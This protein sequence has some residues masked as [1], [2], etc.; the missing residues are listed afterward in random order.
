MIADFC[1]DNAVPYERCGKVIL[2]TTED[3]RPR[4]Q[5]LLDRGTANGVQG[6]ALIGPE[7][8]R[9]IEPHARAV[10]AL[11]SPATAIVD[12]AAVARAMA[13]QLARNGVQIYPRTT[14]QG[15]TRAGNLLHLE[16]NR[17]TVRANNLINCAGLYADTIARKMGVRTDV[18]IIPFRGEYYVLR[19]ERDLVRALIYPVP[20][21]AFPFLG[22]SYQ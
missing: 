22:G 7:Q 10:C 14:V 1:E 8:L 13:A 5:T 4:L 17:G 19:R 2:A 18:H 12:F 16:T 21:P 15:I 9:E 11:H 20:D 3:E 6:L